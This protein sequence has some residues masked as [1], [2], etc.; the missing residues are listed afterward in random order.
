ML[1]KLVPVVARDLYTPAPPPAEPS[2]APPSPQASSSDTAAPPAAT[3][4]KGTSGPTAKHP[5]LPLS[6]GCSM[7]LVP[8]DFIDYGQYLTPF[9]FYGQI[10][11]SEPLRIV[12]QL[13]ISVLRSLPIL[14]GLSWGG[15]IGLGTSGPEGPT[16]FSASAIARTDVSPVPAVLLFLQPRV[17]I[18][19]VDGSLHPGASGELGIGIPFG[20]VY[21]AESGLSWMASTE[22]DHYTLMTAAPTFR[23]GLR[24]SI[25]S[26]LPLRAARTMA[27]GKTTSPHR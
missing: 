1:G 6:L 4:P 26:F 13:E 23:I 8:V 15:V 27:S 18:H 22:R 25:G 9:P 16:L 5:L 3:R 17:S 11:H 19:A 2:A 21:L 10:E 12:P 7:G 20:Q 24:R 14:S